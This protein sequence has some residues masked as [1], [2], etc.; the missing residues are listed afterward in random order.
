MKRKL[1]IEK[2][3]QNYE[4]KSRNRKENLGIEKK[5]QKL[6]LLLKDNPSFNEIGVGAP[7]RR[8]VSMG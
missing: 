1:A 3:I 7:S 2:E 6:L 5:I 8:N 4:R